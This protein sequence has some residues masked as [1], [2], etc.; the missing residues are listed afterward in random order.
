MA[1]VISQ[2]NANHNDVD[3][4]RVSPNNALTIYSTTGQALS[5]LDSTQGFTPVSGYSVIGA[6]LESYYTQ[7]PLSTPVTLTVELQEN[8]A[9][10][11]TPRVSGTYTIDV[12]GYGDA[13]YVEFS[14]P[15]LVTA[16]ASTWRFAARLYTWTYT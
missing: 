12:E 9:T 5:T 3:A 1:V 15:Y 2:K 13:F 14:A 16:A 7:V 4:Y 8:V 10:V 11:W 6:W